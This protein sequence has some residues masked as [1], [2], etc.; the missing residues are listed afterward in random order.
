MLEPD[1]F[2]LRKRQW[3]PPRSTP[4]LHPVYCVAMDGSGKENLLL[5]QILPIDDGDNALVTAAAQLAEGRPVAVPTETVYGLAGDACSD[6]AVAEIFRLKGRPSFNPLICHVNGLAMAEKYGRM[7]KTACR[8][9]EAFWPGPLT[10][11]VPHNRDAR[12]PISKLVLAGLDTIALRQPT[13]IMARLADALDR[14]LAAP[15][16]NRS[17]RISTTTADHVA[18]EYEEADLLVL[19]GGPC[20]VG[21]ESTIAKVDRDR[22]ILLR[23]GA[24]QADELAACCGLPVE[25]AEMGSAVEAPGMLASHYAPRARLRLD[26]ISCPAGAHLLA[27]GNAKDKSRGKAAACLN[28]SRSGDLNEAAANLYAYM[29][30][31]DTPDT[32]LICVEPIPQ[33]GIGLAINDRLA[34]AAAPRDKT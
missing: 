9:A 22:L 8:L 31:L 26:T 2:F 13:G 6:V 4:A 1:N 3:L 14:P 24:V 29:K 27:F 21:L 17:G 32:A 23:P 12:P 18:Q 30:A 20:R 5:A 7:G 10:L 28:L 34:R 11:V 15:S 25:Q 33:H 19:D 16:A